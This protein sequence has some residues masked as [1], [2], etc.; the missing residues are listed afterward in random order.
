MII[1]PV[2]KGSAVVVMDRDHYVSEAERQLNDSTFNRV[3][4]HDPTMEFAQKVSAAICE[5]RACNH[6]SETNYIYLTVESQKQGDFI[7]TQKKAVARMFLCS[8]DGRG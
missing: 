8:Q 3:L 4:D 1:K 2:D 5:L 6:I 7:A